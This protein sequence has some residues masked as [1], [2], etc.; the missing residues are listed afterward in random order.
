MGSPHTHSCSWGPNGNE[1]IDCCGSDA[2]YNECSNGCN[3]DVS[4]TDGGTIMSYCHLNGT[5]INFNLGFGPYP[6]QRIQNRIA[7][8]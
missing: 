1:P 3:A 7:N 5:G 8:A 2:G 4:P 6:K